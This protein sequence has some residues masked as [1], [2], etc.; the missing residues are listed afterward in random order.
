MISDQ[1]SY[2]FDSVIS[3]GIAKI[4]KLVLAFRMLNL[5]NE[6]VGVGNI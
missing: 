2:A 4:I 1:Q 3:Q 6:V 5:D